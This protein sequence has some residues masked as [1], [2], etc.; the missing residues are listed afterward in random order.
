MKKR[1]CACHSTEIFTVCH[2]FLHSYKL[3]SEQPIPDE[4]ERL[5]ECS[6]IKL[7]LSSSFLLTRSFA[8]VT[9][10]SSTSSIGELSQLILIFEK[11]VFII[12]R[13]CFSVFTWCISGTF[14]LS[15]GCVPIGKGRTNSHC[16]YAW[17]ID[18]WGSDPFKA[19][20]NLQWAWFLRH[21][22]LK[23]PHKCEL[24]LGSESNC[25]WS[26]LSPAHKPHLSQW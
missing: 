4:L 19:A 2:L 22:R 6:P 9:R 14:G 24:S 5:F 23:E 18:K 10:A 21:Q 1:G 12:F 15:T 17:W 7:S 16:A 11:Q 20:G 26:R 8:D 13:A 25:D 3:H